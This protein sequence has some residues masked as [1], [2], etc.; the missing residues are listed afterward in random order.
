[1]AILIMCINLA[2]FLLIGYDKHLAQTGQWRIPEKTL[3]G[4]VLAGG[5]LG[6]CLG[7]RVFHHKTKKLKFRVGFPLIFIVEYGLLAFLPSFL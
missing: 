5:G 4:F 1:M 2:A 7:M 3:F 6:G